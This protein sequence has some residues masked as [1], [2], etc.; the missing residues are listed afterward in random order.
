MDSGNKMIISC[1]VI[2]G[3]VLSF[4]VY[5]FSE[6]VSSLDCINAK[7]VVQGDK[8]NPLIINPLKDSIPASSYC[9]EQKANMSWLILLIPAPT[10]VVL[11]RIKI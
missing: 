5:S 9:I 7:G 8:I 4:G 6:V 3:C 11:W 2:L 1:F 10:I